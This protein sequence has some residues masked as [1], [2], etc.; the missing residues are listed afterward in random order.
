MA[1]DKPSII[2]HLVRLD[3]RG[4]WRVLCRTLSQVPGARIEDRVLVDVR[5]IETVRAMEHR[6]C[7]ACHPGRWLTVGRERQR[8]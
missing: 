1:K 6:G 8:L 4:R 5:L 7:A 2:L 3:D